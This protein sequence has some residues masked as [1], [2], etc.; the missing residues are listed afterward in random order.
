MLTAMTLVMGDGLAFSEGENWKRKRKIMSKVFN[1]DLI[2]KNI[3]K[4]C[5]I[6]DKNYEKFDKKYAT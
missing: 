3:P 6:F 4:I 2:K 5:Q 1:F